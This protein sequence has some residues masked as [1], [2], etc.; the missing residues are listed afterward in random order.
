MIGFRLRTGLLAVVAATIVSC[1]ESAPAPTATPPLPSSVAVTPEPAPLAAQSKTAVAVSQHPDIGS[2]LVDGEGFTLYLYTPDDSSTSKCTGGC[3]G[4]WQ[5]L[6]V[7][8]EN[9]A[10]AGEGVRKDLFGTLTRDDGA[11]QLTYNGHALYKF[12]ADKNP[13]DAAGHLAS[14]YEVFQ[15]AQPEL[16]LWFAVTPA[17][18]LVTS[19]K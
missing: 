10:V 18:E 9:D 5:P 3:A 4:K 12:D 17:G 15:P 19:A 14:K 7:S 1:S 8:E 6:L 16:P 13:G 2:I 11:S